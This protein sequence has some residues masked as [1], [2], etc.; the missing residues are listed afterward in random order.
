MVGYRCSR[1]IPISASQDEVYN[2]SIYLL[3][4]SRTLLM[5]TG[6]YIV[7]VD[8]CV[9]CADTQDPNIS[10]ASVS[11]TATPLDPLTFQGAICLDILKDAWSPV[12]IH[13]RPVE[14]R[15]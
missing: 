14:S 11:P 7:S 3:S 4:S 10:S 1:N 13:S 15:R 6:K 9:C 8:D 12:S 2:V 5:M